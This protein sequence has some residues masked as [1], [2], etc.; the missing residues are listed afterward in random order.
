MEELIALGM[1]TDKGW[2]HSLLGPDLTWVKSRFQEIYSGPFVWMEGV[3]MKC[4]FK[5]FFTLF[6]YFFLNKNNENMIVFV[7]FKIYFKKI[8]FFKQIFLLFLLKKN[9]FLKY[10]HQNEKKKK[11]QTAPKFPKIN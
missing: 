8:N 3:A 5:I 6:S 2:V 1:K 10:K 11:Y 7:I 4:L 9:K